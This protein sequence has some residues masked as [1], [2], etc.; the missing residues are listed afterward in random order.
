MWPSF[1]LLPADNSWP[2]EVDIMEWQGVTPTQDQVTLWWKLPNGD[3]ARVYD[4]GASLAAAYHTYGFDWQPSYADFYF[5]RKR[6]L[7]YTGPNVPQKAMFILINLAI[8]GWEKGQ[9][10]PPHLRIPNHLLGRLRPRLEQAPVLGTCYH[11]RTS[12]KRSI[13]ASIASPKPSE[14]PPSSTTTNSL[15]GHAC[16]SCHAMSSGLLTSKRPWIKTPGTAGELGRLAKQHP[17]FKPRCIAPIMRNEPSEAE[18]ESGVVPARTAPP[19]QRNVGFL[20]VA[21]IPRRLLTHAGIG[22][23]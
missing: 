17:V 13:A 11:E 14:C 22:I 4:T 21:P 8:G 2:P 18:A 15:P 23:E 12:E 9:L 6:I 5:D 16:D 19:M 7:H 20:P 10:N 1:W 3:A